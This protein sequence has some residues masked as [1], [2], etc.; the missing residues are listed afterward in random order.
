MKKILITQILFL[1]LYYISFGQKIE[2]LT[3]S[4]VHLLDFSEK[5]RGEW[6]RRDTLLNHLSSGKKDWEK[7]TVD[8]KALLEKFQELETYEDI[9]DIIGGGCSWYCGGGPRKITA[10]SYLKSQGSIDYLPQNAHDLNYKNAWAEGVSGYGIGEYLSY[11]FEA[12]TPRVTEIIVV[13]GYVKSK[14]AYMN[15]SRVKKLKMYINDKPYAILNLEDKI[16][17]Q[18]F[19]VDPIGSSEIIGGENSEWTIKFE[20]LEVYKGTKFEDV[21]I[22]EIYFDGLDVHCFAKGTKI[23][24]KDNSQKNIEDIVLG[25]LVAWMDLESG[26]IK[27]AKV[28][29]LEKVIHHGLIT[30]KFSSGKE[31]TTT[32]DHPFSIMHKGWA[33]LSPEQSRQYKG[34]QKISLVE[35]GD[36]FMTK[37]GTDKLI[38]IKYLKG[39]Q[40]TYTLSKLSSGDNFIA[41]GFIVGIEEW[42][43]ENQT[44]GKK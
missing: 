3:P 26:K 15:N 31:I 29:K 1:F 44:I 43:F 19:K 23:Q 37:Q 8:E 18:G 35:I 39:D 25:D 30:Y 32:K 22:S 28:E 21:V 6:A 14:T 13:N 27:S 5:A 36:L 40:E 33:S 20:I 9:W 2:N 41:N 7:L 16:A 17:S 34:F 12:N 4:Y 38:E 42:D 24:M 10:S 11:H